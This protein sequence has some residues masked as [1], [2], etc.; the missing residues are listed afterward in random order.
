MAWLYEVH[1]EG[2]IEGNYTTKI[3]KN[4]LFGFGLFVVSEVRLF[5]SFFWAFLHVA[6]NPS[7]FIGER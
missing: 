5:I 1:V 7:I 4:I 6:I 3:Q 2:A